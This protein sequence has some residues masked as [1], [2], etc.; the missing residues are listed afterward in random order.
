MD[1]KIEPLKEPADTKY[2]KHIKIQSQKL[3]DFHGRPMYLGAHILVPEGF[4]EHPQTRYPLMI[5]HGH[6]PDDF[7]GF[8]TQAPD[9]KMDTSDYI[10]RFGIYG[11]KKF[12]KQEA[13]NFYKQ[14][15]SK[16]FP[17]FLIVEI[18]HANPYYDDSYAVNSANVGPYGDAIMYELLPEIEKKFRGIGQ[19]WARF[20][21]G[22]STGGWE[23]LAVQMFYPD[24]Y[25]GVFVACHDPVDFRA[26]IT[27]NI[28]SHPNA[29][30]ML[31]PHT[32]IAQPALRDYLGRTLG[33]VRGMNQYELALGSHA[34]SGEQFDIWQAAYGPVGDD[35]Y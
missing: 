34:R 2:V 16:N 17:R 15:I 3:S 21:Y 27:I 14:W 35:G 11:Y 24:H 26:Y 5:Y 9:S 4:D 12:Q 33:T 7:G 30:Y 25:N 20:T 1:Q 22:G 10:D 23:A 13:Y 28:Y 31:G 8:S 19:G 18:Q 32:K 6:F 29:F